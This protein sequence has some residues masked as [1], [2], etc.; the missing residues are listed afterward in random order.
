MATKQSPVQ[1]AALS[2]ILGTL[3]SMQGMDPLASVSF[4]C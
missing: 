2:L 4:A 3:D 1:K